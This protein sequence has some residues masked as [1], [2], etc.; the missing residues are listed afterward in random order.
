MPEIK[1]TFQAGKMNKDLDE[2]LVPNGEYRDA[3]NIQVRTSDGDDVGTAQNIQGNAAIGGSFAN[4]TPHHPDYLSTPRFK[5]T[6][7]ASVTDEKSD[8]VYFFF[9]S[10]DPLSTDQDFNDILASTSPDRLF[11]DCI[12]EQ[13]VDGTTLPV[14]VDNYSITGTWQS[15]FGDTYDNLV[16]DANNPLWQFTI[17]SDY[18]YKDNIR[19]EMSLRIIAWIPPLNNYLN[20]VAPFFN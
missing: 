13:H 7:V 19:P 14:V 12:I 10:A 11:I 15:I 6:V 4:Y 3:M 9:A 20:L 1:H 2:R 8:K 16:T 17:P 5:Q 18:I